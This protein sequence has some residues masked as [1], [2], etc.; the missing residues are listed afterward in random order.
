[1]APAPLS[2]QKEPAAPSTVTGSVAL[3]SLTAT[4]SAIHW[5]ALVA[6][7]GIEP[8]PRNRWSARDGSWTMST[9]GSSKFHSAVV[10]GSLAARA[11]QPA[12]YAAEM[13]CMFE[14]KVS[15]SAGGAVDDALG[16]A[17]ATTEGGAEL[18]LGCGEGARLAA[19]E[20]P[21][22]IARE[23]D[24][25]SWEQPYSS[26]AHGGFLQS[27][28]RESVPVSLATAPEGPLQGEADGAELVASSGWSFTVATM[29]LNQPTSSDP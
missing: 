24:H 20:Q 13:P 17:T 27:G 19:E 21:A 26:R 22:A 11:V 7:S 15:V 23:R 9:L 29:S 5:S 12:G 2:A 28:E 25:Q 1:M 3:H 14:V 16:L 4:R 6:P 8:R 10:H 18:G